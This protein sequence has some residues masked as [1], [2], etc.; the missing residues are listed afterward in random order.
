MGFLDAFKGANNSWATVTCEEG[1]G[2]LGPEKMVDNRSHT[3]MISGT[4]MET[5]KF[6]RSGVERVDVVAA[7]SEWIKYKLALKTGKVYIATFLVMPQGKQ[8]GKGARMA[9]KQAQTTISMGLLNFEWW[10]AGI[11]YR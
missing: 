10:L 7:T 9:G 3:L 1:V 11:L 2:Y 5:V 6:D 8:S 4:G